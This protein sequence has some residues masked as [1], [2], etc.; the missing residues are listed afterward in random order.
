MVPKDIVPGV[1]EKRPETLSITSASKPGRPGGKRGKKRAR[2]LDSDDDITE[3]IQMQDEQP[4][5]RSRVSRHKIRRVYDENDHM[6]D[7]E[8]G[9]SGPEDDGN[10]VPGVLG[11][12]GDGAGGPILNVVKTEEGE[13]QIPPPSAGDRF[14]ID[15]DEEDK[16]KMAMS[17][18]Y[19]GHYIQGIYLCIIVEP[20][21]PLSSEQIPSVEPALS[22][23][24]RFRPSPAIPRLRDPS[25]IPA[26]SRAGSARLRS[27]TPLFL[28]D[29]DDNGSPPP[30]T[31]DRNRTLP[32]VPSFSG[33]Q[34]GQLLRTNEENAGGLLVFSQALTHVRHEEG[35]DSD[36]DYLRGDADEDQRILE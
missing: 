34:K 26:S 27:E 23:E 4:S 6:G 18:S 15:V 32:P 7:S 21:P 20:Y 29:D 1:G 10:Y 25:E 19:N 36:E 16:P 22:P 12:G 28:P 24:E 9:E 5:G 8:S 2:P 30:P 33:S 3:D 13:I 11:E 35:D 31:V 14:P 17:L